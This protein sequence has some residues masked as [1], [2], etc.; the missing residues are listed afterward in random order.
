[1]VPSGA[2]R[3]T[4]DEG[5]MPVDRRLF[6]TANEA[7]A[8]HRGALTEEG[9]SELYPARMWQAFH[10]ENPGLDPDAVDRAIKEHWD[11]LQKLPPDQALDLLVEASGGSRRQ[12]AFGIV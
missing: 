6:R 4:E 11:D 8:F 10:E 9:A 12:L 5:L 2:V 7:I 1:M 3:T